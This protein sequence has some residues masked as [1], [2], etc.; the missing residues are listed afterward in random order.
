MLKNKT[1]VTAPST[2][3]H[4]YTNSLPPFSNFHALPSSSVIII[5]YKFFLMPLLKKID[6]WI[7]TAVMNNKS[8]NFPLRVQVIKDRVHS[9]CLPYDA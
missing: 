5:K 6:F 3:K 9:W 2:R 4:A 8:F 1:Y 7:N